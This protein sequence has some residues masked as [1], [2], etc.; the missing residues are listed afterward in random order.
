M[1]VIPI[2][3]TALCACID[4]ADVPL[5]TR[6][7]WY[8]RRA[9]SGSYHART[10][11]D[12]RT[13]YMH[14]LI[15]GVTDRA[16]AIDHKDRDGLNN[17]RS[18]IRI[19]TYRQNAANRIKDAESR[20]KGISPNGAGWKAEIGVRGVKR[21]LG[22]FASPTDAARAYDEAARAEFGEF[23]LTNDL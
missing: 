13:V 3:K 19:A 10:T 23:A 8:L 17:Q 12:G 15:L 7:R 2:V 1:T 18:N 16:V 21:Y 14:R 5:V 11:V 9:R 6:Y 22:T 20:Y 4:D